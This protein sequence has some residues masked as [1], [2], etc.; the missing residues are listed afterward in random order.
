MPIIVCTAG[1]LN[2]RSSKY[3]VPRCAVATSGQAVGRVP[4]TE[5]NPVFPSALV[6]LL[7]VPLC[8]HLLVV[9][10]NIKRYR[11][12]VLNTQAVCAF[13]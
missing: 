2:F 4:G 3:Y 9:V 10:G 8:E 12:N 5:D 11:S 6:V 1:G 13:R 7:G